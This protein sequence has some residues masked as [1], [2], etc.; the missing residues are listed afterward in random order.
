MGHYIE[1]NYIFTRGTDRF[2]GPGEWK[3]LWDHGKW[4]ATVGCPQCKEG[5]TLLGH[6]VDEA[7]RV[8]PSVV[9]PTQFVECPNCNFHVMAILNGWP[10][11]LAGPT[12]NPLS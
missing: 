12:P 2:A 5:G 8:T 7:G 1:G 10:E 3:P 11:L 4:S 6:S 9:C